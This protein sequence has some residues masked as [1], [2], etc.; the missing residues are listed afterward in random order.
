MRGSLPARPALAA[1]RVAALAL[2]AP[3]LGGLGGG[4]RLLLIDLS[5]RLMALPARAHLR[6]AHAPQKWGRT[7]SILSK[8]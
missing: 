3:G 7:T 1:A 6:L 8:S 4:L 2:S 5:E